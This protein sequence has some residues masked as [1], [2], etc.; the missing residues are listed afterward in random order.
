[1][2]RPKKDF[3]LSKKKKKKSCLKLPEMANKIS[4]S[5]LLDFLDPPTKKNWVG[6][7]KFLVRN[8]KSNSFKIAWYGEK[9]G[10]YW[11]LFFLAP[12]KKI[13]G[14]K[15]MLVKNEKNQTCS[16][17]PDMARKLVEMFVKNEKINWFFDFLASQPN[18]SGSNEKIKDVQNGP[19]WQENWSKSIF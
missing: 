8:E 13:W 10:R 3:A 7:H 14:R 19:K 6:E 1:M 2:S 17:L 18:K 9:F 4:W 16:K 5:R 15:K 12:N 11:F